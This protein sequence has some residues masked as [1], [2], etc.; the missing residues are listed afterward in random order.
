MEYASNRKLNG[1]LRMISRGM[2]AVGKSFLECFE[3]EGGVAEGL[4]VN[5]S[6]SAPWD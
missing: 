1:R 6:L 5:K 2:L 4:L 3:W